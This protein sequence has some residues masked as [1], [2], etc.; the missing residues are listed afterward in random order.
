[1]IEPIDHS[2]RIAKIQTM[3][4]L[5]RQWQPEGSWLKWPLFRKWKQSRYSLT[6]KESET[7]LSDLETRHREL[8]RDL[9]AK[10]D[11]QLNLFKPLIF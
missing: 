4:I 6:L 7:F 9:Y 2:D 11:V 1:M 5:I 8:E 3:L 10:N